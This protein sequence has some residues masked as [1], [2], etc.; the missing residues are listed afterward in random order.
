[1]TAARK[2]TVRVNT[3][4]IVSLPEHEEAQHL[5]LPLRKLDSETPPVSLLLFVLLHSSR[6]GFLTAVAESISP[7][8]PQLLVF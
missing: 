6:K 1:M 4:V 3:T 2:L 8:T 7:T 5:R